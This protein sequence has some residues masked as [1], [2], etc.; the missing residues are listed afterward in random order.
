[1]NLLLRGKQNAGF[2]PRRHARKSGRGSL[3][4]QQSSWQS[5][6]SAVKWGGHSVRDGRA[7]HTA[8][9]CGK[10][11]AEPGRLP[12][13]K[14]LKYL[15]VPLLPSHRVRARHGIGR[16]WVWCFATFPSGVWLDG[17]GAAWVELAD[18][19]SIPLI[20]PFP[21]AGEVAHSI[22]LLPYPPP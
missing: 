3:K 4:A 14:V 11:W 21:V 17:T 1:M 9:S 15:Q 8:E 16:G 2:S 22:T 19:A 12:F 10:L 7:T 5:L 18:D 13:R 20:R 6:F